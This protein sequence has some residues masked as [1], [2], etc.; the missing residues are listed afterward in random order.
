MEPSQS[1]H[2]QQAL[3]NPR[4][5]PPLS[6]FVL[7]AIAGAVCVAVLS[8]GLFGLEREGILGLAVGLGLF[9]VA[10]ITFGIA[11][12]RTYPHAVLGLCNVVTLVRLVIVATLAGALIS[13]TSPAWAIF[14]IATFALT[15]DGVDGWLAR[16]QDLASSFGARFDMEVDAAFALVLA[17]HA[18]FGEIAGFWVVLL[19]L[20]HYLF[21]AANRVFPWLGGAL[22]ERFSRKT[23][24]VLQ[25][26]TLVA[27][28]A[29]VLDASIA[30]PLIVIA[31]LAL[32]WSFALDILWLWRS[33]P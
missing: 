15:L 9:L 21:V 27:L 24:C 7:T 12:M 1:P 23:V 20:P 3:P 22:P 32:V 10:S 4:L 33:R 31:S 13:T 28:Q 17:L 19:G 6:G 11:L 8:V 26:G 14:V 16:R 30:A 2:L 5:R 29:P 25:I 18:A